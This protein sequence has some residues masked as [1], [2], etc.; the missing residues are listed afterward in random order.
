MGRIVEFQPGLDLGAQEPFARQDVPVK[1]QSQGR[2]EKV[3][4]VGGI[5]E[6]QTEGT[7]PAAGQPAGR[8]APDQTPAAAFHAQILQ[9]GP[10]EGRGVAGLLH[11]DRLACPPAQGLHPQGAAAGEDV[12]HAHGR[13]VHT[14]GLEHGEE[15]F[16]HPPRGGP[17]PRPLGGADVPAPV[18]SG[19]DTHRASPWRASASVRTSVPTEWR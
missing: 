5:D 19:D 11:E 9:I 1:K 15:G 7:C 8:V 2:Q 16:P 12:G 18:R 6:D 10:D 17:V 13:P 14:L 3:L 4:S